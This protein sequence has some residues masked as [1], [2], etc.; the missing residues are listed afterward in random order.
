MGDARDAPVKAEPALETV[1][2]GEIEIDPGH[3]ER[4]AREPEHRLGVAELDLLSTTY[5]TDRLRRELRPR[6][7]EIVERD[8]L[9]D[10]VPAHLASE[11]RGRRRVR[12]CARRRDL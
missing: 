6:V 2:R 8:A 7:R 3:R 9:E 11:R 5:D 4:V 10:E 12:R 1:W